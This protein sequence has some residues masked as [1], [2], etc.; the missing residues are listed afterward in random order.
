MALN[1]D[2]CYGQP[3]LVPALEGAPLPY[4]IL[5]V[6]NL[7][8]AGI[9]HW[10]QGIEWESDLCGPASLYRCPTCAQNNGDT[11]P[12]KEYTDE[13]VPLD[14]AAPFTVYASFACSPIGHW[15]DAEERARRALLSG[16]ERALEAMVADGVHSYSRGLYNASTID[17][18][19][20]AGTPVSVQAGVA[21]L[22]QY[23]G[24]N[25]KGQGVILGARRDILLAN[26]TGKIISPVGD[27]LETFL[28]TPVAALSGIN[29]KTGPGGDA[30][31]A[32]EAWLFALGSKPRVLRSDVFLTSNRETS[33][34]TDDNNLNIL[35]ERTYVVGWDCFTVG[36]LISTVGTA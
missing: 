28:G 2:P 14:S 27:H 30:P 26:A 4:G 32:N 19:P 15:D 34:D 9:G 23:I 1:A 17:I 24:E 13:G 25:G 11:V 16:E 22:E 36:V 21:L 31:E 18:T 35:A 8:E 6:S 20:T 5:S 10:Q 12:V 3:R 7:T 29:G 33:L